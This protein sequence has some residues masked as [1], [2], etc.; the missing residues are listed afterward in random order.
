MLLIKDG[1]GLRMKNFN[2]VGVHLKIRFLGSVHEKPIQGELPKIGEG[3]W[4]VCRFK[5][6]RGVGKKERGGAFEG[7]RNETP[8]HTMYISAKTAHS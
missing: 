5:R 3:A 8:M 4:A 1:M 2:I 6:G 7:G